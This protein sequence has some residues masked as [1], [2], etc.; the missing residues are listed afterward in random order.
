MK[1]KFKL[2]SPAEAL[3]STWRNSNSRPWFIADQVLSSASNFL[4]V[5]VVARTHSASELGRIA[6][7]LNSIFF[8]ITLRQSCFGELLLSR[9]EIDA[10]Q[11]DRAASLG[12]VALGMVAVVLILACEP[13][14]HLGESQLLLICPLVP[15]VLLQDSRRFHCFLQLNPRRAAGMDAVW[16]GLMAIAAVALHQSGE[17]SVGVDVASWELCG[18]LSMFVTGVPIAFGGIRETISWL[19]SQ[20]KSIALLASQI[21]LSSGATYLLVFIAAVVHPA[22]AGALRAV[23]TLF[24]PLAVL[25]LAERIRLTAQLSGRAAKRLSIGMYCHSVWLPIS[26]AVAYVIIIRLIPHGTGEWLLGGAWIDT[27]QIAWLAGLQFVVLSFTQLPIASLITRSRFRATLVARGS[28]GIVAVAFACPLMLV[29]EPR[30]AVYSG[31]ILGSLIGVGV[32]VWLAGH[33]IGE[34][35]SASSPLTAIADS[36]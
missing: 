21:V 9:K 34:T 4:V 18:A 36:A 25:L 26:V 6:V 27:Q 23:Q 13:V 10:T 7:V 16:V 28:V 3:R 32:A 33:R 14:I 35:Q 29:I 15:L 19:A 11:A 5:V 2:L 24:G 20:S 8:V 17:H 12:S 22:D 30:F 1:G 31:L